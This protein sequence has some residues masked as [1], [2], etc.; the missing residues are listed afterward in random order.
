MSRWLPYGLL[1]FTVAAFT[2]PT[3]AAFSLVFYVCV[4][5]LALLM[6]ARIPFN[7]AAP[8]PP[9]SGEARGGGAAARIGLALALALILWSGLT[10]LW[11]EGDP[12]RN[13]RYLLATAATACF[14]LASWQV[15]ALPNM[16]QRLAT[17]LICAGSANAVFVLASN[18]P[19]LLR[20][21]RILGWG[22][23]RQPILGGSIMAL[24]CLTAIAR[25]SSRWPT[26]TTGRP[27]RSGLQRTAC[28]AAITVTA[29]FI[30][31]MQ[32][33]GALVGFTGGTLLLGWILWRWRILLAVPAFY[34]AFAPPAVRDTANRMFLQRG[35]SHR[36]EIWAAA[37]RH[38]GERPLFGHGLAA[39]LPIGPTGFPHSLYLSLLFYSGAVG[40][41]LFTALGIVVTLRLVRAAPGPLR[42]WAMGLWVNALLA[43]LTDFGQITKGPGPL[44]FILWLPIM[45]ALSLP[46]RPPEAAAAPPCAAN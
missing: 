27:A 19:A 25:S 4:M 15:L 21:D 36:L 22:I 23:T 35:T 39:N 43:G 28:I 9:A 2:L 13:H 10:L 44:W 20:G 17:L 31:A 1:V 34:V 30:L 41:I 37:W 7:S 11:G 3:E 6:P 16:Q 26:N 42:A 29:T 12:L 33:R 14:V 8:P 5:P 40:F 45:L 24:A 32:S 46:V 38:I 18:A